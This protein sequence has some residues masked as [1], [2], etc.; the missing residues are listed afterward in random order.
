MEQVIYQILEKTLVGGAFVYLLVHIIK[1]KTQMSKN[2]KD[3]G[4]SL[5]DIS[6]TLVSINQ[7]IQA[8]E[9]RVNHLE[10]DKGGIQNVKRG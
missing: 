4:K 3:F 10:Y 7:S 2:L 8:L 5:Q 9:R 6:H 1:D